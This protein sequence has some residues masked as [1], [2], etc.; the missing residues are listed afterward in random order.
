M[1]VVA[2]RSDDVAGVQVFYAR[3]ATDGP[4]PSHL[5][6]AR[7]TRHPPEE[8]VSQCVFVCAIVRGNRSTVKTG[9]GDRTKKQEKKK[10]KS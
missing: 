6:H 1:R 9:K 2:V 4:H 8:Y 5:V 10:K 3:H 7:S